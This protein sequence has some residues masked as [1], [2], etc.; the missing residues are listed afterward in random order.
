MTRDE[1]TSALRE[2][3][4]ELARREVTAKIF[5]VGG[6][7]MVLAHDARDATVDGDAYPH[8]QVL[9]AARD[10]ARGRGL[11]EDWLHSAAR[12]FIPVF[13]SP[14]WRPL[15]HFGSLEVLAAD[16]RPML[17]MKIRA[18]RGQRDEPDIEVLARS[19]GVTSVDEA[20]ALYEEY[21]PEDP[22]PARA[23]LVL[24]HL[25]AKEPT[26]RIAGESPTRGETP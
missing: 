14:E 16:D 4:D 24:R 20:L 15:F 9:A 13:R 7:V 10:V 1:M 25:L 22:P 6:A 8:D 26:S 12:G 23:L 5:V 11:P 21:F 18:S 19:C 17:A 2:L 3:G